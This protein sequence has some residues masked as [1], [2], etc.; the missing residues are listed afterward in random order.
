MRSFAPK[1]ALLAVTLT[2]TAVAPLPAFGAFTR[3]DQQ[4]S[5]NGGGDLGL[6]K[7]QAT[8]NGARTTIDPNL[9]DQNQGFSNRLRT[10]TMKKRESVYDEGVRGRER[11]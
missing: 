11:L 4:A 2:L 6:G 1:T 3:P 5:V 7:R 9:A 8:Q 10:S